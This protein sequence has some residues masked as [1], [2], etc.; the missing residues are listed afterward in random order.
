MVVFIKV[1]TVLYYV[2]NGSLRAVR[3]EKNGIIAIAFIRSDRNILSF[4]EKRYPSKV[5]SISPVYGDIGSR[6]HYIGCT[7][8][9]SCKWHIFSPST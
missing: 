2:L 3:S 9:L 8:V 4:R 1:V 5:I 6:M 7:S